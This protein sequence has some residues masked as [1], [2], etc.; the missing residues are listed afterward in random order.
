MVAVQLQLA[1]RRLGRCTSYY[2]Q[3]IHV[4]LSTNATWRKEMMSPFPR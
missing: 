3:N 1:S 2:H 4:F